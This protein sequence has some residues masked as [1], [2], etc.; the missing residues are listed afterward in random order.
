MDENE[1]KENVVDSKDVV[2]TDKFDFPD[3]SFKTMARR[4]KRINF[5]GKTFHEELEIKY[6]YEGTL[7]VLINT[8]VYTAEV[9]DIIVVNPYEVHENINI[10]GDTAQYYS[11]IC[12][13]N[14]LNDLNLGVD[15]RKLL[16]TDGK[17]FKNLIHDDERLRTAIRLI[18]EEMD[19]QKEF[20]RAIERGLLEQIIA[21]LLRNHLQ[22][23]IAPTPEDVKLKGTIIPALSLIHNDY[24][25]K[26]TVD[27]LAA[28]CCIS[29]S[30]FCRFFKE[31]TGTTPI[32]YLMAYRISLAEM[33]LNGTLK[34]CEEIARLCGFEEATYFNKCF[35]KLRG[36]S[37]NRARKK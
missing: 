25:R 5:I 4:N 14:T 19:E 27:E 17:K 36:I 2:V 23:D 10:A 15:L 6:Y 8:Q 20:H 26:I 28:A 29:V 9:G 3:A 13:L 37:P 33:L 35:K 7:N 34:S 30:S 1:K 12:D 32:Q 22:D 21:L 31:V 24:A 16:V 11:L 18:S